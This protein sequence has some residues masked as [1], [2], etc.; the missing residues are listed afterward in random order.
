MSK[1]I[2]TIESE[3][4]IYVFLVFM[5]YY[6]LLKNIAHLARLK[7]AKESLFHPTEGTTLLQLLLSCFISI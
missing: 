6:W 1:C 3:V 7:M 4:F 2:L 5:N